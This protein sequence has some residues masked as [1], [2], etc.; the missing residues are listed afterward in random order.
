LFE[1]PDDPLMEAD[2]CLLK[3]DSVELTLPWRSVDGVNQMKNKDIFI[4]PRDKHADLFYTQIQSRVEIMQVK[5]PLI[6]RENTFYTLM[7]SLPILLKHLPLEEIML[8]IGCALTE[9]R[10]IIH[11]PD[12]HVVSGCLLAL[13]SLL[14]PLKW[15]GVIIVTLPSSSIY[16]NYLESPVPMIVG[17]QHLPSDFQLRDGTVIV[18]PLHNAAHKAVQLHSKDVVESHT[19]TLPHTSIFIKSLKDQADTILRS[20]KKYYRMAESLDANARNSEYKVPIELDANS[21]QGQLFLSS[22]S[23]FITIFET[24]LTTVVNTA[25]FLSREQSRQQKL[26]AVAKK[27]QSNEG[28]RRQGSLDVADDHSDVGDAFSDVG[29]NKSQISMTSD[30]NEVLPPMEKD[31]PRLIT[32]GQ[33]DSHIL[34]VKRLMATQMFEDYCHVASETHKKAVIRSK[35][36]KEEMSKNAGATKQDRE[37]TSHRN[38]MRRYSYDANG[39]SVK[40]V[41]NNN[42]SLVSLFI[43]VLSGSAPITEEQLKKMN[44][45]INENENQND[46]IL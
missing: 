25:V 37:V 14:R 17:M 35:T 26:Q 7:W 44:D 31:A 10:V 15:A 22:I 34:F 12:L 27:M 9:M 42:D 36:L 38:S 2:D 6:D 4:L 43:T 20:S 41:F 11:A 45:I 29:D 21:D 40:N 23:A 33:S 5:R 32:R 13:T 28:L 16:M 19:L 1:M 39:M 3:Y 30:D 46:V 8:V 24:H 18:D